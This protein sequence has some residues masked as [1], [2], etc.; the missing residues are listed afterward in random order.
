MVA[1]TEKGRADE[2]ASAEPAPDRQGGGHRGGF[3]LTPQEDFVRGVSLHGQTLRFAASGTQVIEALLLCAAATIV[4]IGSAV[5]AAGVDTMLNGVTVDH[6]WPVVVAG[7]LVAAGFVVQAVG[8]WRSGVVASPEG[9]AVRD[10]WRWRRLGWNEVV[11]VQAFDTAPERWGAYFAGDAAGVRMRPVASM[12]LGV[13]VLSN[14]VA[15]ALPS[16]YS[17]AKGEGLSM[18]GPT[19]T[20]LKVAALRRYREQAIGPWP[21]PQPPTSFVDAQRGVSWIAAVLLAVAGPA[22]LWVTLNLASDDEVPFDSL[23]TWW[24][25]AIV[26]LG[27]SQRDRLRRALFPD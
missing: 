10:R 7:V 2:P 12:S 14:G 3:R 25:I 19:P 17:A 6:P 9:L 8:L 15:V 1:V 4:L 18:G 11:D 16:C 23:A 22:L 13:A 20:E 27:L 26:V 21:D 24:L 5:T